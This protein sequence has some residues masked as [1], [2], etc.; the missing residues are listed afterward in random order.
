MFKIGDFVRS[1]TDAVFIGIIIDKNETCDCFEVA[2]HDG[3]F[4]YN[5]DEK[6]MFH[7]VMK[8]SDWTP[9][10]YKAFSDFFCP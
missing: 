9:Y 1:D 10:L 3:D 6:S 7:H 4:T 8:P 2:W 5:E